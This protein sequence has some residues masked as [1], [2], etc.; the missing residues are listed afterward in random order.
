MLSRSLV[1]LLANLYMTGIPVQF[2]TDCGSETTMVFGFANALRYVAKVILPSIII[3]S[4]SEICFTLNTHQ[5]SYLPMSIFG[6]SIISQLKGLGYVYS[7]S[8]AILQFYASMKDL[9]RL[10]DLTIP[11]IPIISAF[12]C[13]L[14]I[15]IKT[16]VTLSSELCQWL[17]PKLLRKKLAEFMEARNSFKSRKDVDKPGPSGMSRNVAFAL[18]HTWG[19]RNLLLP[20]DVTL[21]QEIKEFMGGDQILEFVTAE[22]SAKIQDIYD[23]LGVQNLDFDNVW[24]IFRSIL[25]RLVE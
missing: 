25:T 4:F 11:I 22:Y 15:L 20:V 17:W 7:W 3:D 2:T 5:R 16:E 13:Y 18:P 14:D 12:T 19:G 24:E 8:L 9:L 1:A 21:I 10:E 6:V 23:Q